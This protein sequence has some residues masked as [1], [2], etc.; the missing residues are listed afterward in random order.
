MPGEI[1]ISKVRE[2]DDRIAQYIPL[3]QGL[4][5]LH[6]P[7]VR[8]QR[9]LRDPAPPR[10]AGAQDECGPVSGQAWKIRVQGRD[11]YSYPVLLSGWLGECMARLGK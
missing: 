4:C 5:R 10:Q 9:L 3:C 7:G 1:V 11:I 2:G 6:L 8:L